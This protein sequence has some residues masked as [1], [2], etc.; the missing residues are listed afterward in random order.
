MI[1]RAGSQ[2]LLPKSHESRTEN[3]RWKT[4]LAKWE[5]V[6]GRMINILTMG[7][8]HHK[9]TLVMEEANRQGGYESVSSRLSWFCVQAALLR[10]MFFFGEPK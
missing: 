10:K 2:R 5:V 8:F 7:D 6:C 4:I 3:S 1:Q 9:I